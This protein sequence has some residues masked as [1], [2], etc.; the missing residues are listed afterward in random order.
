M[1]IASNFNAADVNWS[2]IV[3]YEDTIDTFIVSDPDLRVETTEIF[4][5]WVDFSGD[6]SYYG[7]ISR[8]AALFF[9]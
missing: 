7:D 9:V 4:D 8:E 3:L 1:Q 5:R 6:I 2:Q